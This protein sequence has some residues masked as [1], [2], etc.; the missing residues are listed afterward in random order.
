[1]AF[2]SNLFK[3]RLASLVKQ[4]NRVAVVGVEWGSEVRALGSAGYE[5]HAF[6]PL[7]KFHTHTKNIATSAGW[8]V[9]MYKVAAGATSGGTIELK[10]DG[11]VDNAKLAKVDDFLS[12]KLDVLSVD[13]QGNE[14]DVLVG[15]RNL[16]SG[17]KV[18]SL[19]IEIFPCNPK[20][21]KIFDL[22]DEKYVIFDFVPWG[23][24]A[25]SK[26]TSSWTGRSDSVEMGWNTRPSKFEPYLRWLCKDEKRGFRWSQTDIVAIRRD[27]I[28]PKLLQ[29]LAN[30][31]NDVLVE[32]ILARN[33]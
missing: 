19:W 8:N 23:K 15:A 3:L 20:V 24:L 18:R 32:S 26:L 11:F 31:G 5:V 10:Y 2:H 25:G 17:G 22:L 6:E 4:Y 13:I 12:S 28:T 33:K 29:K 9:H 1:M 7:T 21:N 27:L 16:I 14:Y 30:I